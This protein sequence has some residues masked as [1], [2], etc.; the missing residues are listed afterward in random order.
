MSGG[1]G[2]Y[3]IYSDTVPD[4][5]KQSFLD[6]LF[7]GRPSLALADVVA[8]AKAYLTA[9]VVNH[10]DTILWPN[11]INMQFGEAP[12]L[13]KVQWAKSGDPSTPYTPDVRSPG[14][15]AGIQLDSTTAV[16]TNVI[17]NASKPDSAASDTSR[18]APHH[19]PGTDTTVSPNTTSA[20]VGAS[21]FTSIS[22]SNTQDKSG[23][24]LYK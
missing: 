4:K 17:P 20:K 13:T 19:V 22:A 10:P 7:A 14:P 3:S 5:Q 1:K 21:D 9:P 16:Q 24:E 8:R 11:P 2:K 23:G 12:D 18:F 6:S 15:A